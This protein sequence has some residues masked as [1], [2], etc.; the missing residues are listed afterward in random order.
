MSTTSHKLIVI[1]V[2]GSS[3]SRSA[4]HRGPPQRRRRQLVAACRT[5][6]DVL[7]GIGRTEDAADLRR[8]LDEASSGGPDTG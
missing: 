6:A 1:G 7:D 2:D 4:R 8:Q 5:L 3:G